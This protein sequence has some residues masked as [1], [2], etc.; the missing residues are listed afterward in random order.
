[1]NTSSVARTIQTV[2]GT[3]PLQHDFL[4]IL[5]NQFGWK[6]QSAGSGELFWVT[7]TIGGG[8]SSDLNPNGR[9][10]L[11]AR[12]LDR[13]NPANP[14]GSQCALVAQH[15]DTPLIEIEVDHTESYAAFAARLDAAVMVLDHD[16]EEQA[17]S[18]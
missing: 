2:L 4:Q 17:P 12:L 15:G 16:D 1:M 6:N 8:L 7:K 13:P 18:L 11:S 14:F 10:Q 3:H 9:R 5:I